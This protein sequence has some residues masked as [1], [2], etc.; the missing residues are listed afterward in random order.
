LRLLRG[1]PRLPPELCPWTPLGDVCPTDFLPVPLSNQNPAFYAAVPCFTAMVDAAND[2][3][4]CGF[5]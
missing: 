4:K 2:I 1:A 5:I 3:E